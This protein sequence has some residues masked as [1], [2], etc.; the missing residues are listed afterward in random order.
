MSVEP[1]IAFLFF[2][3]ILKTLNHQRLGRFQRYL[4]LWFVLI[5]FLPLERDARL[6][7]LKVPFK[8]TAP[9]DLLLFDCFYSIQLLFTAFM[10]IL[11]FLR[12]MLTPFYILKFRNL[13]INCDFCCCPN[14]K[15]ER[16]GAPYAFFGSYYPFLLEKLKASP[17]FNSYL[18]VSPNPST[19]LN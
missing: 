13:C 7:A 4:W 15:L 2:H 12:L 6:F 1:S 9:E 17:H 3:D 8:K 10:S 5:K 11:S 16:L 18:Y 19:L 14:E